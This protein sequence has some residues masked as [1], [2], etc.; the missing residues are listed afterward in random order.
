[1]PCLVTKEDLGPL[2]VHEIYFELVPISLLPVSHVI[3][4]FG[5]WIVR[6]PERI[7]LHPLHQLEVLGDEGEVETFAPD[8]EILVLGDTVEVEG[9]EEQVGSEDTI[10]WLPMDG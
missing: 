8:V 5:V 3:D 9:L 10:V 2:F 6:R 1:M 7:C 4:L